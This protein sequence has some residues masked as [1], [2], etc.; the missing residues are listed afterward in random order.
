[1]SRREGAGPARRCAR[2]TL[3]ALLTVALLVAVD[4]RLVPCASVPV[5]AIIYPARIQVYRFYNTRAGVHFYTG[6]EQERDQVRARLGHLYNYEGPA[7]KALT[8]GM[9]T[10]VPLYRFYNPSVGVHFYT[11]SEQEKEDVRAR[12][13][14]VYNFEGIAYYV[15]PSG[16]TPVYRF[17]CRS[18]AV[19]FYTAD[20][21]E[22]DDV[23]ARLSHL[24]SYEGPAF[25]VP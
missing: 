16:T 13:S 17:F 9:K 12:L 4:P 5:T 20:P 23:I 2:H 19:H 21:T 25:F 3:V 11:A 18:K 7:Y 14:R 22:R 10:A 6:S 15:L 24:Y 8:G 1:M